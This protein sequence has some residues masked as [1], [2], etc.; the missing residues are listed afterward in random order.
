MRKQAKELKKGDKINIAG[1]IGIVQETELSEI[2]KHGKRK[3]R[4]IVL[5]PQS[6]RITIIRPEDYPF[7]CS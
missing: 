3:V 5:T 4:I 6:E 7:N 2:G 1:Q